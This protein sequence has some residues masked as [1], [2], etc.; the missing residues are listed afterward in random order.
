[1]K[2]KLLSAF[3][4][5]S[6]LFFAGCSVSDSVDS[7]Y[8]KW[9]FSGTV[10][11]S[12]NGQGLS[13]V[14]ITYQDS[15]GDIQTVETDASGNF[16]IKELPYG[17]LNFSFNYKS[18]K[19]KDTV[20]YTPKVINIGSSGESSR[21]EGVV[22]GTALIVRMS[23]LNAKLEGE[24]YLIEE[25]TEKKIPVSKAKVYLVHQDTAFVNLSPKSFEA[26][27]D[28]LG[29]FNFTKLPADTGLVL[30]IEAVTHKNLR[31]I[32][33]DLDLPRLK[34]TSTTNLGRIY[35]SRDTLV[36]AAPLIKKSNVIDANRVGLENVSQLST[37]YYIFKENLKTDNLSVTVKADTVS[38]AVV[39]RVN[40]DTLFLD[41]TEAFPPAAE[42]TV[43]IIAY[44]KDSG[45]RLDV[46]LSGT[47]AFKTGKGIYA[48]TS[49]T[50]PSNKNF[51][52]S[53]GI[54]DTIWVKFSKTLAKN[55]DRIQWN[56]TSGVDC[57][58]YG[59]G[60]YANSKTWINKD[61]LFVQMLE[62]ILMNRDRGDSVGM[63]ITV[64]A[65][66]GSYMNG[67]VVRTELVVP[68]PTSKKDD[69]EKDD[70]ADANADSDS[71]NV[72]F[73]QD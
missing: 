51:K 7:E 34:S 46:E 14:V 23:P 67:F 20:Y 18:I 16:F 9:T 35:L 1:M 61:T 49:N 53:F 55:T 66:D 58:I 57:T 11:D 8:S 37:P 12:E 32:S 42:I 47:S 24:C 28:S 13:K 15:D 22:A 3:I 60:Y 38:I 48:V 50:W 44:G 17:S 45:E 62:G 71:A 64:Y 27:T 41:H 4:A 36:S 63:N 72:T 70:D 19:D 2:N 59:N 54:S 65:D 10:I 5:A 21:M 29:K 56:Y 52:A 6:F 73:E 40:K 68:Q 31:Y 43:K 26:Q 69:E 33:N 39:P 30:R 25:S